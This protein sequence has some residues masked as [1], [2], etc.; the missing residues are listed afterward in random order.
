MEDLKQ[1]QANVQ[2][3]EARLMEIRSFENDFEKLKGELQTKIVESEE[4]Q[5]KCQEMQAQLEK[6][7]S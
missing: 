7:E 5:K 6:F 1:A 4:W 2:E 3:L